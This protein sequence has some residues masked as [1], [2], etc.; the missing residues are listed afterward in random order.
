[1][2]LQIRIWWTGPDV[3]VEIPG[4]L[5]GIPSAHTRGDLGAPGTPVPPI[6][7]GASFAATGARRDRRAGTRVRGEVDGI[8]PTTLGWINLTM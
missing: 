2:S 1:V 8:N 7:D 4:L 3:H 5:S 6:F